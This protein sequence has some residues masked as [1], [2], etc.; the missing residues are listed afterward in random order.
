MSKTVEFCDKLVRKEMC[1]NFALFARHLPYTILMERGG[2]G[3]DLRANPC[4]P[5]AQHDEFI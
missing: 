1:Q 2:Y 4:N 5:F 3:F